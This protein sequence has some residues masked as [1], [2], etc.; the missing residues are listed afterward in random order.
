MPLFP[1]FAAGL[2]ESQ[3]YQLL[4]DGLIDEEEL[5]LLLSGASP[6]GTVGGGEPP[7]R[8]PG[9][10]TQFKRFGV[11]VHLDEPE[12]EQDLP[13]PAPPEEQFLL[14]EGDASESFYAPATEPAR[15]SAPQVVAETSPLEDLFGSFDAQLAQGGMQD[16]LV[17]H[18]R[19]L[20]AD[21]QQLLQQLFQR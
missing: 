15:E 20:N 10:T 1:H 14:P 11:R 16:N 4:E 21:T 12:E 5:I 6:T 3:L 2:D 8:R 9:T 17:G 19:A 7:K 13:L 18:L